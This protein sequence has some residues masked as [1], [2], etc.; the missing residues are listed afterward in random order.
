M[1]DHDFSD[2]EVIRA[3]E[4]HKEWSSM[5]ESCPLTMSKACGMLLSKSAL[6]LI[7]RKEAEVAK[8]IFAELESCL[9]YIEEQLDETPD[10]FLCVREDLEALKQKYAEE[11]T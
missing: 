1:T 4:C 8:K 9:D 3:L 5:C 6:R 11:K 2:E 7:K 10:A